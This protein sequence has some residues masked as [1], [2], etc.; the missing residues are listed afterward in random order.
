M[1]REEKDVIDSFEG[2]ESYQRV[3][4]DKEKYLFEVGEP[5]IGLIEGD[6]A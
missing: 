3:Y 1:T 6:V 5:M 2:K 4:E